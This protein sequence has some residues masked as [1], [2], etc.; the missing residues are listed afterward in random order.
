[1]SNKRNR[2]KVHSTVSSIAS[3]IARFINPVDTIR[4]QKTLDLEGV[5]VK[6]KPHINDI[7]PAVEE[8]L[9]EEERQRSIR[10]ARQW[11]KSGVILNP[12]LFD[13]ADYGFEDEEDY[14]AYLRNQKKLQKK[15][16]KESKRGSRG[17]KKKYND[18]Y[19]YGLDYGTVD[20]DEF[21][22]QRRALYGDDFESDDNDSKHIYFYPDI[23]DELSVREFYSLAEFNEFCGKNNYLVGSVDF[24]NLKNWGVIHCCLDPVDLE[25]GD[26][27]VITDTSYGGLYWTVEPDLSKSVKTS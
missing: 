26:N 10:I 18:G 24:E 23:N 4:M 20:H 9:D 2:F 15:N 27:T 11:A 17:G 7:M 22:E 6:L 3:A 25:Y 14:F 5:D 12:G 16:K 1:M 21:W 13:G 19:S 8:R